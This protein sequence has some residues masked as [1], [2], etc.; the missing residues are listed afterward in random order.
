MVNESSLK[1]GWLEFIRG[2]EGVMLKIGVNK[3][4][5]ISDN[6]VRRLLI[7]LQQWG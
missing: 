2:R 4:A 5:L 6:D 1:I 7:W 3:M